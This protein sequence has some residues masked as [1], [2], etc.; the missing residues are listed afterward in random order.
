M[1][2]KQQQ[3][4]LKGPGSAGRMLAHLRRWVLDYISS[5]WVR[6]PRYGHGA[7][8]LAAWKRIRQ[9][10]KLIF[11]CER[12]SEKTTSELKLSHQWRGLD[13]ERWLKLMRFS[14][15]LLLSEESFSIFLYRVFLKIFKLNFV[16]YYSVP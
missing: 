3:G 16:K 9:D 10:I 7:C 8:E 2:A 5:T 14:Y 11:K 15:A 6:S 13:G 1:R 4:G 12:K